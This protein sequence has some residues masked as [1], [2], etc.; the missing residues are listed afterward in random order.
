MLGFLV[1]QFMFKEAP[2][3]ANNINV[4]HKQILKGIKFTYNP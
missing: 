3:K 2:F 4:L 1:Y